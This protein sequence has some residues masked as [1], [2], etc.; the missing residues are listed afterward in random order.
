MHTQVE[1]TWR[2]TNQVRSWIAT[3]SPTRA[4]MWTRWTSDGAKHTSPNT[5]FPIDQL[6]LT[7]WTCKIFQNDLG[8]RRNT[9]IDLPK[10]A[11]DCAAPYAAALITSSR[12]IYQRKRLFNDSNMLCMYREKTCVSASMVIH[13]WW[14]WTNL[15]VILADTQSIAINARA[16]NA[17]RT[18][19]Q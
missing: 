17:K 1:R 13:K 18:Q 14:T 19:H 11:N 15:T 5:R 10:Q 2:S 4:C 12:F 9:T 7:S 8:K 3:H 16:I 6:G